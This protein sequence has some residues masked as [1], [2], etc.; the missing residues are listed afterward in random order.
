MLELLKKRGIKNVQVLNA[1]ET[2]PRE[3]F[4]PKHLQDLAYSD[5]AL[6][7]DCGQTISQPYIVARMTESVYQSNQHRKILEIGTGSGYQAA[8]LS[9]LYDEVY[10]VERIETLL[11]QAKKCLKQ[12][13]IKN[14]FTKYGDG[15]E[16]WFEHAPYNA[17]IVTAAAKTVPIALKEQLADNGKLIIPVDTPGGFQDLQLI[18]RNGKRFETDILDSVMF[19]PLLSGITL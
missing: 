1:F 17:I 15:S 6:P 18:T 4:V 7:I 9:T 8:I 16:G 12:L 2:I 13:K 19:V 3:A 10:T 14:I 5:E 11:S